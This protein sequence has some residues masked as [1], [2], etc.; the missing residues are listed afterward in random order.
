[1][2]TRKKLTHTEIPREQI[3]EVINTDISIK[4]YKGYDETVGSLEEFLSAPP[5]YE[6]VPDG[7][8]EN[9]LIRTSEF[10]ARFP[11]QQ[12]FDYGLRQ[13][14]FYE[15]QHGG[16]RT[17]KIETYIPKGFMI[18]KSFSSVDSKSTLYVNHVKK[19]AVWSVRGTDFNNRVDM[20]V[21]S[22]IVTQ[23]TSGWADGSVNDV[24]I[25]IIEKYKQPGREYRLIFASHSQGASI[26]LALL[27]VD[28]ENPNLTE[29]GE[30]VFARREDNIE[31]GRL[32]KDY[33]KYV[34]KAYF[35]NIGY[36]WN[37]N[38]RLISQSKKVNNRDKIQRLKNILVF[39][40]IE[41]DLISRN[42][43]NYP[44]GIKYVIN[45]KTKS[46]FDTGH[47]ILHFLNPVTLGLTKPVEEIQIQLEESEHLY[48]KSEHLQGIIDQILFNINKEYPIERNPGKHELLNNYYDY[49]VEINTNKDT[50][51]VRWLNVQEDFLSY[52]RSNS[53][54]LD[55]REA[56]T[57]IPINNIDDLMSTQQVKAKA[58]GGKGKGKA[59]KA[60]KAPKAAGAKK[61]PKRDKGYE[62]IGQTD[63]D[64]K[65]PFRESGESSAY[66]S[67]SRG[68]KSAYTKRMNKE[69][70]RTGLSPFIPSKSSRRGAPPP[71]PKGLPAPP[72]PAP[73]PAPAQ[74]PYPRGTIQQVISNPN[75]TIENLVANRM[76]GVSIPTARS[77][78]QGTSK[79]KE[80][81]VGPDGIPSIAVYANAHPNTQMGDFAPTG[82]KRVDVHKG[83]KL[84]APNLPEVAKR[85]PGRPR[86]TPIT[87]LKAKKPRAKKLTSVVKVPKL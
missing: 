1:M 29:D 56:Q 84:I 40:E 86:K 21:N 49:L 8:E 61:E 51:K 22:R 46:F 33:T 55:L 62:T 2:T 76:T 26:Q 75:V 57:I 47:G 35:Y 32:I 63:F 12:Y 64:P 15:K 5:P 52:L 39:F 36:P 83:N 10:Y 34:D 58:T 72:A 78:I 42:I 31:A 77:R 59:P 60:P 38:E 13:K 19:V 67:M 18:D 28:W 6:D 68:E 85:K 23:D 66:A 79:L 20:L 53:M 24:L 48:V 70:A 74:T 16:S 3:P 41:G 11:S 9:D 54:R 4:N 25:S 50:Q 81:V 30:I 80:F 45:K 27:D 43:I 71:Y 14:L 73:A 7:K 82:K 17:I 65:N 37:Y 44:Y 87:E 69:R